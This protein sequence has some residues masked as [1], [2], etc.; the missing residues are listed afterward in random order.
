MNVSK[1]NE[2]SRYSRELLPRILESMVRID[3][4]LASLHATLLRL[5]QGRNKKDCP[6]EE[7]S[8][9]P[10]FWLP[11]WG[12]AQQHGLP[13]RLWPKH[14]IAAGD[15]CRPAESHALSGGEVAYLPVEKVL[16]ALF[17]LGRPVEKPRFSTVDGHRIQRCCTLSTAC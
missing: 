17:P 3:P 11:A 4:A 16:H 6:R 7:G 1:K 13:C 2:K 14:C 10:L 12:N 15:A 5:Q 9:L 8:R